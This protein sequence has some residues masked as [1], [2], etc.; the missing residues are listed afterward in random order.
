VLRCSVRTTHA[1]GTASILLLS[2]EHNCLLY[3]L[4]QLVFYVAASRGRTTLFF[5]KQYT[6][7]STVEVDDEAS[8]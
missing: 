6:V 8:I 7:A 2:L 1:S 4:D 5:S 3:T